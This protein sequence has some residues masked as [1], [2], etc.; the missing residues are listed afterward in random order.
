MVVGGGGGGGYPL[1]TFFKGR[2]WSSID[3]CSKGIWAP[4]HEDFVLDSLFEMAFTASNYTAKI[5]RG[6][7]DISHRR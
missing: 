3:N 6:T 5:F 1:T 4:A 2:G 7:T